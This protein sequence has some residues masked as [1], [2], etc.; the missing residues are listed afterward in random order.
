MYKSREESFF[1]IKP[2]MTSFRQFQDPNSNS[3]RSFPQYSERPFSPFDLEVPE[4]FLEC[5]SRNNVTS[6]KHSW[7]PKVEIESSKVA[8]FFLD[9]GDPGMMYIAHVGESGRLNVRAKPYNP[10]ERYP[11]FN[12]KPLWGDKFDK[13][14]EI[15]N[16]E[17]KDDC[18]RSCNKNSRLQR[19]R[20]EGQMVSNGRS[21]W[22]KKRYA[23]TC[24]LAHYLEQNCKPS[25]KSATRPPST[26]SKGQQNP[27]Y[28]SEL[29][30]NFPRGDCKFGDRC[31]FIHI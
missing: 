10:E 20:K 28:K 1:F 4:I 7:G 6:L 12:R 22:E 9:N 2:T 18:S 16:K 5:M 13:K 26:E 30:V 21:Y 11:K 3:S 24:S 23:G 8:S 25:R 27:K 15:E 29:C 31:S 19:S 17:A 14:E